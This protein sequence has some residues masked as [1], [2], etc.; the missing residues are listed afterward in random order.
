MIRAEKSLNHGRTKAV[1]IFH[2]D[3]MRWSVSVEGKFAGNSGKRLFIKGWEQILNDA[4]RPQAAKAVEQIAE[5]SL[6]GTGYEMAEEE[7]CK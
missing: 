7:P 4:V 6:Q 2:Q 3:T 5:D 1:A